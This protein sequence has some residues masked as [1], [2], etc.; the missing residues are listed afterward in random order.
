MQAVHYSV[1]KEAVL[2]HLIP[3][4]RNGVLVDCTVGEGGHS[5]ALLDSYPE[6][7]VVGIDRDAEM[8]QRAAERLRPY[9]SRFIP[10]HAWFDQ[11]L[12]EYPQELSHPE[13]ILLDLGISMF[14]FDSSK[15]GFSFRSDEK[16]D[17][18]LDTSQELKA[19]DVINA[20]QEKRLADLIY[21]YGEERYSRRIARAI[22]EERKKESI[23]SAERLRE[24]IFHSVPP[25]Y[26][27]GKI[28]PATKTFQAVRIEVNEELDRLKRALEAAVFLLQPG[29]RAAVISFHSLEDRIVKQTFRRFAGK[30]SEDETY[31]AQP[32]AELITKKPLQAGVEETAEN[33]ASRSA[34]LRVVQRLSTAARRQ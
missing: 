32:I 31:K 6:I 26:R 22:C 1:L 17:M 25:G 5:E 9:G 7:T 13:G 19:S 16:L 23:T 24:I 14:H 8:L 20:Y 10:R 4:T 34:K 30:D 18:R 2:T 15:R 27:R 11:F 3:V 21:Q 33:P 12:A 29:G 28:H